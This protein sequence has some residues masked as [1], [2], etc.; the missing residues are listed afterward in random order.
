MKSPVAIFLDKKIRQHKINIAALAILSGISEHRMHGIIHDNQPPT[1]P[2]LNKLAYALGMNMPDF[3]KE[4][5]KISSQ[6][7]FNTTNE[8]KDLA[9]ENDALPGQKQDVKSTLIN[10]DDEQEAKRATE[11]YTTKNSS[12]AAFA[13][14]ILNQI[15]AYNLNNEAISSMLNIT[16]DKLENILNG[17]L[18]DQKTLKKICTLFELNFFSILHKYYNN[19]RYPLN[20][21]QELLTPHSNLALSNIEKLTQNIVQESRLK[22]AEELKIIETQLKLISDFLSKSEK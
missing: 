22:T 20:S 7:V 10:T 19:Y 6:T 15:Q 8:E 18:P 11:N 21:N 13:R 9:A 17:N 1:N 2:E 12:A 5:N 4:I 3:K 14:L 16:P